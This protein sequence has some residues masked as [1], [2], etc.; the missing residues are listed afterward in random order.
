MKNMSYYY[1]SYMHAVLLGIMSVI[2]LHPR[3]E[4]HEKKDEHYAWRKEDLF[5]AGKERAK[6]SRCSPFILESSRKL[7][8]SRDK[9]TPPIRFAEYVS[10]SPSSFIPIL[11]ACPHAPSPTRLQLLQLRLRSISHK[12]HQKL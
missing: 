11:L 2:T 10:P 1:S 6:L 4:L 9:Q 7:Q 3:S 12:S 8:S 5:L